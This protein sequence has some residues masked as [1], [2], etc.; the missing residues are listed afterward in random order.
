MKEKKV[1]NLNSMTEEEIEE[2]LSGT[3]VVIESV[4]DLLKKHD[5]PS[6]CKVNALA[7][8]LV[9]CYINSSDQLFEELLGGMREGRKITGSGLDSGDISYMKEEK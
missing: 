4:L 5:V 3:R 6:V 7:N 1:F 8:L 9:G 2:L